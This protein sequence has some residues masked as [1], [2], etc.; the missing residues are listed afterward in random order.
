MSSYQ[1]WYV[2]HIQSFI[3]DQIISIICSAI[4]GALPFYIVGMYNAINTFS[5]QLTNLILLGDLA[6][7]KLTGNTL[8]GTYYAA[9]VTYGS[10]HKE[11]NILAWYGTRSMTMANPFTGEIDRTAPTSFIENGKHTWNGNSEDMTQP[12]ACRLLDDQYK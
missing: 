12:Y 3:Q 5:S 7:L 2:E 10:Y 4:I 8:D 11:C 6:C 9:T 1:T